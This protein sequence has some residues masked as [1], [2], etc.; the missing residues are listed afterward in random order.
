MVASKAS[1]VT[2]TR[3]LAMQ[4]SS[5][6]NAMVLTTP[7]LLWCLIMA[8][9]KSSLFPSWDVISVENRVT[10]GPT[11]VPRTVQFRLELSRA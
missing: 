1:M 8:L 7:R 4:M 6:W 10:L 9:L 2:V 3:D 11:T 5:V